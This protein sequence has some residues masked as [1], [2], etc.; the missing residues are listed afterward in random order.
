REHGTGVLTRRRPPGSECAAV[1]AILDPAVA[2]A[3][4]PMRRVWTIA[5]DHV[6]VRWVRVTDAVDVVLRKHSN[7]ERARLVAGVH[8]RVRVHAVG[9]PEEVPGLVGGDGGEIRM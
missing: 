6:A 1:L 4:K 7:V 8:R 2:D 9:E 5:L 3:G